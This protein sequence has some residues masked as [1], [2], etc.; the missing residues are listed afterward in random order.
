MNTIYLYLFLYVYFIYA[1]GFVAYSLLHKFYVARL[2]MFMNIALSWALGSF[3]TMFVLY[4]LAITNSL[5]LVTSTNFIWV[6]GVVSFCFLLSLVH[7][8]KVKIKITPV[9]VL[10]LLSVGVF[11]VPL[12]RDSLYSYL[13]SWDAVAIW[14][15]KAKVFFLHDGVWMNNFFTDTSVYTYS[16]RAYPIGFPLLITGYYR[17]I[18]F[19]NDQVAQFIPLQFYLNMTLLFFGMVLHIFKKAMRLSIFLFTTSLVIFPNII[20]YSHN[21]YADVAI[22]FYIATLTCLLIFMLDMKKNV[23]ELA[24]LS[25]FV[26]IAAAL[27]KN[28]GIALF[29]IVAMTTIASTIILQIRKK[30]EP[31]KILQYVVIPLIIGSIIILSWSYIGH[32]LSFPT[33]SYLLGG[34]SMSIVSRIKL[35]LNQ[36]VLELGS[37]AKYSFIL[38]LSLFVFIFQSTL[39]LFRRKFWVFIPLYFAA[40]QFAVYTLIY[41]RTGIQL[42]WQLTTSYDRLFLQVLPSFLI[43]IVYQLQFLPQGL[44]WFLTDNK[45]KKKD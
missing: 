44:L 39:Y 17:L 8:V 28:E 25:I 9:N 6:I 11:F 4:A 37:T 7:L 23:Y 29:C 21:G 10:M 45:T 43:V 13:V 41:L 31:L 42:Q 26:S 5:T 18:G 34:Q 32:T 30:S 27:V 16:H 3:I 20:I 38:I 33:D 14:F 12:V 24:R 40:L 15:F 22:S 35:I 2:N 19:A 1:V 36:Y